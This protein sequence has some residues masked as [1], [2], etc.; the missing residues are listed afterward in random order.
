MTKSKRGMHI[1]SVSEHEGKRK[2]PKR[3]SKK[4]SKKGHK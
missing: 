3:R 1:K 4:T 2:A